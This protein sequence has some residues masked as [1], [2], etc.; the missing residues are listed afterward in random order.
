[1]ANIAIF[2]IKGKQVATVSFEFSKTEM[3]AY[4]TANGA[5][6]QADITV[7]DSSGNRIGK[8]WSSGMGAYSVYK[9]NQKSAYPTLG[10]IVDMRAFANSSGGG[11]LGEVISTNIHSASHGKVGELS[12]AWGSDDEVFISREVG[13]MVEN[14]LSSSEK[15]LQRKESMLQEAYKCMGEIA[16]CSALILKCLK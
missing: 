4:L 2:D 8:V 5:L 9:W 14:N 11:W 1:M 7:F 12:I 15:T 10:I 3:N 13:R 6:L 16:G